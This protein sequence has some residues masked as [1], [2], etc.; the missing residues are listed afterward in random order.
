MARSISISHDSACVSCTMRALPYLLA[1]GVDVEPMLPY[2]EQATRFYF[3]ERGAAT[4]YF[5]GFMLF[6]AGA[7]L[8]PGRKLELVAFV[9]VTGLGA[10]D[11][12]L[13]MELPRGF[14][15]HKD[16]QLLVRDRDG[17]ELSRSPV[18]V[19]ALRQGV[20]LSLPLR[21]ADIYRLGF[22]VRCPDG[23]RVAQWEHDPN[24]IPPTNPT[25]RAPALTFVDEFGEPSEVTL[26]VQSYDT[27]ST[28]TPSNFADFRAR[29][30]F[31]R[32]KLRRPRQRSALP[33]L[34]RH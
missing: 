7:Q 10:A 25:F 9:Q 33:M 11:P 15:V 21:L 28:I 23:F 12:K 8:Q 32:P 5:R 2:F 17:K 20:P 30:D 13:R 3:T 26:M 24:E 34:N 16:G 1:A 6:G 4:E 29:I 19:A 31:P 22:W 18:T 14:T 27:L